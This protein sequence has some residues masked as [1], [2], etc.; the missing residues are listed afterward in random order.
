MKMIPTLATLMAFTSLA[1]SAETKTEK[2]VNISEFTLGKTISG[3]EITTETVT[4]HPVVIDYWGVN[5]GPC[6]CLGSA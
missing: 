5:C 3:T 6:I 1:I 4:G 2:K